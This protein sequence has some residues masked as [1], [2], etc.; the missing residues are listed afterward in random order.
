M[1]LLIA[2]DRSDVSDK[3]IAMTIAITRPETAKVLL[4]NV[5]PRQNDFLGQ[6]MRRKPVTDAVAEGLDDH[7][8]LLDRHAAT[9]EAAGIDCE[10]LLI[11]GHPGATVNRESKRWGADLIVMGSHGR[12]MLYRKFVGSVSEEVLTERLCPVLIVPGKKDPALG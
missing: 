5:A 2:V 3:V 10:T 9:L 12:G 1:K 7:R 8:D 11:R 6:Q 4:L